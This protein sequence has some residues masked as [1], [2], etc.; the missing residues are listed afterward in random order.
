LKVVGKQIYNIGVKPPGSSPFL[1]NLV[2]Q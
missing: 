1:K 2:G